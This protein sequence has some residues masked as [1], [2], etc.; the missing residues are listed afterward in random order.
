MASLLTHTSEDSPMILC[1][2]NSNLAILSISSNN[3]WRT[4]DAMMPSVSERRSI[5]FNGER[6]PREQRYSL[7]PADPSVSL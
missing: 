2:M 4:S 6:R 3:S 5:W 7:D 1:T